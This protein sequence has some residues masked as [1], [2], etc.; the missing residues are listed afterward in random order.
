MGGHCPGD[1]WICLDVVPDPLTKVGGVI[2]HDEGDLI[3][4]QLVAK[5]REIFFALYRVN[6]ELVALRDGDLT[7]R[8]SSTTASMYVTVVRGSGSVVNVAG[9]IVIA[10][11]VHGV[12]AGIVGGVTLVR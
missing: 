10:G 7:K 5:L 3:V 6:F 8:P 9:G 4:S 1:P 11:W 2:N 12:V